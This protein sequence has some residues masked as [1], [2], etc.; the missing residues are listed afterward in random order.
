MRRRLPPLNALLAFEAAAR[1]ENLT[2][3][4]RDLDVAQPAITRHVANL[5][6]WVGSDLFHRSGNAV[7]LTPLGHELTRDI[8]VA[9]DRLELAFARIART[10]Q[11]ELLIGASFGITHLWLM[12]QITA[13]RDAAGGAAINFV[14]SER[15]ADF[16]REPVDLSI[17]FGRGDWPGK[18]ADLLFTE[19]TSIIASPEF[20]ARHPALDQP[21]PTPHLRAEWLLEHGDPHGYGWM[22]WQRWFALHGVPDP[23]GGDLPGVANYPTLLDMVRCGEGIALGYEGLDDALVEGGQIM[24]VGRTVHRPGLGYYLLSDAGEGVSPRVDELRG[25]LTGGPDGVRE[26]G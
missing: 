13:L 1:H 20:V 23:V 26:R 17:R 8:A 14:T 15:Y 6:D 7:A 5:E 21:D 3:A 25:F 10:R 11:N 9:F 18:R 19:K 16:E 2:R 12:P 22:T 4:A 24:R